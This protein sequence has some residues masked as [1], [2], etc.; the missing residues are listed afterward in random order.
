MTNKTPLLEQVICQCSGTTR[1]YIEKLVQ[2]GLDV[3]AISQ[4]SGALTG[5]GGCEWDIAELVKALSTQ[6]N[7]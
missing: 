5:C 2:Q 4:R 6:K 1:G 3:D 7:P